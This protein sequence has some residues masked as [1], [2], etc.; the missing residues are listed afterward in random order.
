MCFW[1]SCNFKIQAKGHVSQDLVREMV[2]QISREE[3]SH[4][5]NIKCKCTKAGS[6]GACGKERQEGS[7]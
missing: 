2:I 3:H 4:T 7:Q 1:P 6:D 5:R